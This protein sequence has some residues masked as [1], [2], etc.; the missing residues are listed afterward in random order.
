MIVLSAPSRYP[1]STSLERIGPLKLEAIPQSLDGMSVLDIGGYDGRFAYQCLTRGA[2]RAVCLDNDE[3][4]E[5]YGQTWPAP[6]QFEGVVYEHGD[7]LDHQEQY[8]LVLCFNV[9]YHCARWQEAADALRRLTK[10]TLCLS[11]Y[12]AQGTQGW[13]PYIESGTNY[14][15]A[16]PTMPGLFKALGDAGFKDYPYLRVQDNVVVLRCA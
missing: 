7:F 14:E 10:K 13:T 3:W 9:L 2:S 5:Y 6:E 1:M 8:D 15:R 16:T 12:C 11:T 4:K